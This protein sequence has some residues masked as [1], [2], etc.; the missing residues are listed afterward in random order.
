MIKGWLDPVVAS[1]VHFTKTPED[2]E[3]YIS[4]SQLIK[5]V[6]GDNSYEYK[7]VEPVAD[8]NTKQNDTKAMEDL[9]SKRFQYASEFQRATRSWISTNSSSATGEAAGF[10]KQRYNLASKLHDN[11]WQLDPHVRAR[12]LY[13][14]IGDI[15]PGKSH[16]GLPSRTTS[17]RTTVST[18]HS[19]EVVTTRPIV[20]DGNGD[21]V[22]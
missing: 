13:D 8:E 3:A 18:K 1:K 10:M 14:R 4:R 5:E 16:K 6:G 9:V 11:Y 19:F 2:I 21:E 17:V 15:P 20:V 22:D 12:S 7:Y